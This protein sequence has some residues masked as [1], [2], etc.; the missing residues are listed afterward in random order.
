MLDIFVLYVQAI[1]THLLK[2]KFF[3]LSYRFNNLKN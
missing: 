3:N 2:N 1:G